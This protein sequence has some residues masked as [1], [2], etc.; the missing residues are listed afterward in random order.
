VSPAAHP[1]LNIHSASF[2]GNFGLVSYALSSGVPPSA[3]LDGIT[4]LHA[5][6]ANQMSNNETVVNCLIDHGSDVNAARSGSRRASAENSRT[7][8]VG[9]A[10][11]ECSIVPRLSP[12]GLLRR[13]ELTLI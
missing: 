5:A 13:C 3:V 8:R 7:P 4:P 12:Q 6:C 9:G 11:G 10:L 1:Y 2:T